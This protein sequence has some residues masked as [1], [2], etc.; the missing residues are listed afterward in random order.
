[1][2]TQVDFCLFPNAFLSCLQFGALKLARVCV[3]KSLIHFI[4]LSQEEWN[5]KVVIEMT[6][7]LIANEIMIAFSLL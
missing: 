2:A 7:W 1:M 3:L 5:F 6:G 4:Y